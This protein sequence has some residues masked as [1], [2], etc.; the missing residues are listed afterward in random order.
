MNASKLFAAVAAVAFSG[1]A[2][3]ADLAGANA[4]A[5]AAAAQA[6]IAAKNLNVPAVLVD[7]SAGR[8]RAEVKAEAIAAVQE[9]RA[10]TAASFDWIT[11]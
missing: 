2:F 10:T 7:K 6:S 11:K 8:T 9:H 3:A 4:T 1:S 5:I